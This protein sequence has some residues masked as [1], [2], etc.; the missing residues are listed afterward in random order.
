MCSGK[1]QYRRLV[2]MELVHN[3]GV[4]CTLP[5]IFFTNV[6]NIQLCVIHLFHSILLSPLAKFSLSVFDFSQICVFFQYILNSE[7]VA[8][9]S[10]N[11]NSSYVAPV[12]SALWG[13]YKGKTF[14]FYA[15]ELF[16]FLH[17]FW[18]TC[19]AL[20]LPKIV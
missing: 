16:V 4:T 15:L 5:F 2:W 1:S 14:T 17:I 9:T 19:D 10:C 3:A 11:V 6:Y 13:I 7:C 18:T 20:K 12:D 8:C